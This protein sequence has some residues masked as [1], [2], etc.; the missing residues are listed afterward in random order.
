MNKI[1]SISSYGDNP[2]YITG[3]HKQFELVKAFYPDWEFRAY[4][5]DAKKYNMPGANIIEVKDGSHGVFWRFEPLFESEE[6][7][8]IVR[9]ADGR[10]TYRESLAVLEWVNSS[11]S[12]HIFRDHEAH[13]E[14]PIIACAFGY[15][16]KLPE[17]LHAVMKE[18]ATKTN[19]YTNDQVYLRDFVY[20]HVKEDTLIHCMKEGWFG[21][22]RFFL[23]NPYC[24]CGNGF[25]ENDM[26]LYPGTLREMKGFDAKNVDPKYKFDGG[27]YKKDPAN[28]ASRY[29]W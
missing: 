20:E 24:F 13:Y 15:K 14:F 9:D 17:S 6:N 22:S 1:V 11:K 18:F 5:D 28:I 2:R 25:D 23:K 3:A 19:Y 12:F 21:Q 8:V 10:I 29:T 26:P 7:L 27:F 16:G 4:V